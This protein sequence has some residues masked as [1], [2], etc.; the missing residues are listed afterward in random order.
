[1]KLGEK[2]FTLIEL[3]IAIAIIG[4]ASGAASLAIFQTFKGI[5]RN[6]NYM[7]VV[8]QVEN[9][10]YWLSRDALMADSINADNLTPPDFLV[11]TWREWDSDNKA[12]Y[13]VATYSFPFEDLAGGI[14]K[15]KRTHWTLARGDEVTL[16]AKHIYYAPGDPDNTTKASY[17]TPELIIRIT[18]LI[19][20]DRETRE[21][22]VSRRPNF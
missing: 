1:M 20:D 17:D 12:I 6:N 8:R 7:T 9:A 21:Y 4:V 16:V 3:I 14:G 13:H 2:G 22:R 5:E 15:L 11:L 19:G 10:G 18:A